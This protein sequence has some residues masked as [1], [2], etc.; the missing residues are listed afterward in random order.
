[1]PRLESLDIPNRRRAAS[2]G[3]GERAR[4][5]WYRTCCCIRSAEEIKAGRADGGKAGRVRWRNRRARHA[6]G[7]RQERGEG[8]SKGV[9]SGLEGI[10][11]W[12]AIGAVSEPCSQ[13]AVPRVMPNEQAPARI[14]RIPPMLALNL[15][16]SAEVGLVGSRPTCACVCAANR[17]AVTMRANKII[18]CFMIVSFRLFHC[19]HRRMQSEAR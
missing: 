5:D 11:N 14:V 4:V 19:A 16:I 6:A 13:H 18:R 2:E 3:V 8:G 7:L 17:P 12:F 15:M 1:M 10:P 9:P